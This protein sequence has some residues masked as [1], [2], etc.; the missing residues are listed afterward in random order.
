MDS[1][2]LEVVEATERLQNEYNQGHPGKP[3]FYIFYG[4]DGKKLMFVMQNPAVGESGLEDEECQRI[5]SLQRTNPNYF[6][7]RIKMH[8]KYLAKWLQSKA[9]KEFSE[10]FVEFLEHKEFWKSDKKCSDNYENHFIS[11]F[12]VTDLFKLRMTTTNLDDYRKESNK[13]QEWFNLFK[14]EV[15]NCEPDYIFSFSSRT[16]KALFKIFKFP[17]L[18]KKALR[19]NHGRKIQVSLDGKKYTLV[20]LY[21]FSP[22]IYNSL[23]EGSYWRYLDENFDK[24]LTQIE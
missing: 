17:P 21:H 13:D 4:L 19:S 14:K 1:K 11:E 23:I 3:T 2:V 6:S 5:N 18:E 20:P 10:K 15:K 7:E 22:R 24:P 12:Y 8:Q 16:W 9:N